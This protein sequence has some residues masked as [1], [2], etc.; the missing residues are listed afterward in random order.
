MD[1]LP[2]LFE[3]LITSINSCILKRYPVAAKAE[4]EVAERW[5]NFGEE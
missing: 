2:P 5:K 4:N 3:V 1:I